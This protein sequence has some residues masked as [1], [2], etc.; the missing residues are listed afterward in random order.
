MCTLS[1][2]VMRHPH[3][4]GRQYPT[5]NIFSRKL[6]MVERGMGLPNL[7]TPHWWLSRQ[8]GI[9]VSP[10]FDVLQRWPSPLLQDAGWLLQEYQGGL[11]HHP[12]YYSSW[13]HQP[14]P[15]GLPE[16]CGNSG[17][18]LHPPAVLP[19]TLL[20]PQGTHTHLP[21][22]LSPCPRLPAHTTFTHHCSS[23]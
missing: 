8:Q 16:G 2:I 20:C 3:N 13:L 11:P 6:E 7:V 23:C 19:P 9:I 5:G 21:T 4:R 22:L 1:C 18:L 12:T 14:G 15:P 10:S 17:D